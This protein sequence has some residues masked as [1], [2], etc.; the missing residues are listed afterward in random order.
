MKLR[1]Q[2]AIVIQ[3]TVQHI[4]LQR[5]FIDLLSWNRRI[6]N[7]SASAIQSILRGKLTSRMYMQ[8]I[9]QRQS[10][11]NNIQRVFRGNLGQEEYHRLRQLWLEKQKKSKRVSM[12]MRRYST[13]GNNISVGKM[14]KKLSS[15][16]DMSQS[17]KIK[18]G[19]H[20]EQDENNSIATT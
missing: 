15:V 7:Q 4:I 13:Y 3:T 19:N 17:L 1:N 14:N 20:H 12:H 9:Q 6:S 18:I 11:I 16:E 2:S 10:A 5:Q 8:Q